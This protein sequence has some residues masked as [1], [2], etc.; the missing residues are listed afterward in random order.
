VPLLA[1][2]AVRVPSLSFRKNVARLKPSA[3]Q[4]SAS[5]RAFGGRDAFTYGIQVTVGMILRLELIIKIEIVSI[6]N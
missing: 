3:F 1:I 4:A 2:G 6:V 5:G